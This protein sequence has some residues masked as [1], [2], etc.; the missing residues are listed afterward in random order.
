MSISLKRTLLIVLLTAGL[1]VALVGGSVKSLAVH[2][3]GYHS[4]LHHTQQL[5][6]YCPAPPT[7]C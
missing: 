7:G 2:A 6:W 5:A 3:P 1:L 4:N